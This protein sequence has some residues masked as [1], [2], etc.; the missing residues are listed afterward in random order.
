[1]AAVSSVVPFPVA[2]AEVTIVVAAEHMVGAAMTADMY[3]NI[4]MRRSEKLNLRCGYLLVFFE[5]YTDV[6][7]FS[8]GGM[9]SDKRRE[10]TKKL[11][12][13]L[14]NCVTVSHR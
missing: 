9:P 3:R 1:M 14:W 5:T 12:R 10:G 13:G 11:Y 7:L 2:P 6:G 4:R 8:Y